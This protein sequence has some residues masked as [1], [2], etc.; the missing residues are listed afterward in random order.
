MNRSRYPWT[1]PRSFAVAVIVATFF[2]LVSVGCGGASETVEAAP[3]DVAAASSRPAGPVAEEVETTTVRRGLFQATVTASGSVHAP[4]STE[5]GPEVGGRLVRVM[6]D[7]GD[8][9]REGAPVF[10][11]DPEPYQLTLEDAQAGLALARAELEQAEQEMKRASTLADQQVVPQ[12]Q[13]ETQVTRH[14]VQKARV[15]QAE[16]RV[17]R[18]QQDLERTTVRAPYDG[19]VVERRLHEGAM[20]NP[21]SVVL[22]LQQAGGYEALLA[23]PE[24]ARLPVRPGDP[25]R[26]LIEGIPGG[27][28]S[29]VR[30]VNARIDPQSRTYEVRVPLDGA[31]APLKAGAF[32]RAEIDP[33]P[34]SDSLLLD[35]EAILTRDGRNYVF[36]VRGQRAEMVPIELGATGARVAAV[37]RGIDE[38]DRLVVGDVVERLADGAPVNVTGDRPL[39]RASSP[40]APAAESIVP[41]TESS[42]RPPADAEDGGAAPTST[43]GSR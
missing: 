29:R 10:R 33:V 35:R 39:P 32:V 7:V 40:T 26:V 27:I 41:A 12:Q 17:N 6:V 19:F 16:A 18:A 34:V 37:N 30:A 42:P 14:A 22:T 15:T 5:L 20:L 4:R 43:G 3:A 21:A 28:D 8:S 2:L 13:L 11:I 36:R 31:G 38:N 23:V 9:V 1:A 25:A 24:A